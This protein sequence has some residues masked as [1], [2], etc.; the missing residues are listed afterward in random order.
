MT[1]KFDHSL[2]VGTFLDLHGEK[3]LLEN[4]Y[5]KKKLN[6]DLALTS[7]QKLDISSIKKKSDADKKSVQVIGK[8]V[9]SYINKLGKSQQ[10]QAL[11]FLSAQNVPLFIFAQGTKPSKNI[12]NLFKATGLPV[13]ASKIPIRR[14]TAE[15]NEIINNPQ[16]PMKTYHGVF[17]DINNLGVLILG[18]SGIGKSECALDLIIGGSKLIADDVIEI[19]RTPQSKLVGTGPDNIKYLMEI[20]GIGI[21]NIRDLFGATSVMDKREIDMVVELDHWNTKKEYERL[22]IETTS[23]NIMDLEIPYV[24]IPVSPGRNIATVVEVAVRNQI[25]KNSSMEYSAVKQ[26]WK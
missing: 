8:T 21:V 16:V 15:I 2:T 5:N 20:R 18:K 1:S 4:L 3:L 13:F 14:L 17:V 23:Y 19:R 9:T 6:K 25:L 22:G 11:K 10:G 26:I 7:A 24:M 12:K